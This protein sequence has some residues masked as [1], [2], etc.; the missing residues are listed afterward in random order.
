M[1]GVA[2]ENTTGV[3]VVVV[4]SG[5]PNKLHGRC[6]GF[7]YDVINAQTRPKWVWLESLA[8]NGSYIESSDNLNKV[9]Q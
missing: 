5:W 9:S 2:K 4:V 6:N 8:I 1:P 7:N 3:V